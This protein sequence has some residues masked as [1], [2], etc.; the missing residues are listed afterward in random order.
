MKEFMLIFR[1]EADQMPS[2]EQMQAILQQWQQ[3]IKGINAD[4]KYSGTNRLLPEGKTI[5]PG[6]LITDGPFIESKELVGGY[7]IIKA[8][9]LDD[10]VETAKTCPMLEYGGTV[11]VRSVMAIDSDP[12]SE[13][14]L[15]P[16]A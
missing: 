13:S 7:L 9:T 10:A 2:A 14:F 16:K 15:A 3:W 11:E 1:R 6:L 8:A 4:G 12:E 5:K